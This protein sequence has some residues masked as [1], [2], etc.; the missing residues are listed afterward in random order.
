MF[1]IIGG[2]LLAWLLWILGFSDTIIRGIHE[3]FGLNISMAGYYVLF[4]LIGLITNLITMLTSRNR[5][6]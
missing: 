2:L 3:L 5:R 4:G 1:G 6:A